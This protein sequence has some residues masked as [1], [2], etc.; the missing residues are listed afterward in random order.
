MTVATTAASSSNC[1]AANSAPPGKFPWPA[2]GAALACLVLCGIPARRRYWRALLGMVA[3]CAVLAS[4]L[5]A[6][7]SPASSNSCTTTPTAGTTAGSYTVTVTGT[8]GSV[9]SSATITVLVQ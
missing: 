8:S 2:G 6:C 4:G 7:T 1:S 3:L 5:A 9:T